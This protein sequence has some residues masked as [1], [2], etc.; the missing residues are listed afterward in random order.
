MSRSDLRKLAAIEGWRTFATWKSK[1]SGPGHTVKTPEM[2]VASIERE[3]PPSFCGIMTSIVASLGNEAVRGNTP[4]EYGIAELVAYAR[5]VFEL[6]MSLGANVAYTDRIGIF[7]EHFPN[8]GP[9]PVPDPESVAATIHDGLA[10]HSHDIARS[11]ASSYR[12]TL[13]VD[14]EFYF[15]PELNKLYIKAYDYSRE[16]A[17]TENPN[18]GP[19]L[20]VFGHFGRAYPLIQRR[21]DRFEDVLAEYLADPFFDP[22]GLSRTWKDGY[23]YVARIWPVLREIMILAYFIERFAGNPMVRPSTGFHLPVDFPV[24]SPTWAFLEERYRGSFN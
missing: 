14:P 5:T 15:A 13:G 21:I 11:M 18:G 8:V 2:I 20:P 12:R 19:R 24:N 6:M 23:R 4:G 1:L 9:D 3:D 7:S 17:H 22:P 10:T 16:V